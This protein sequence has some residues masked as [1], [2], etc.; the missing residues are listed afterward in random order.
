MAKVYSNQR[1]SQRGNQG[2]TREEARAREP[3]KVCRRLGGEKASGRSGPPAQLTAVARKGSQKDVAHQSFCSIYL[4]LFS[5][6]G[7]WSWMADLPGWT[8][9]SGGWM[10]GEEEE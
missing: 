9:W 6:L 5:F 10:V 3:A 2:G 7:S 8:D 4:S 1:G